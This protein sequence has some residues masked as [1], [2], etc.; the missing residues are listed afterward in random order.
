MKYVIGTRGSK[1]ALAQAQI[2]CDRLRES[3][4]GGENEFEIKIIKTTGDMVQDKPLDKIG[5]KGLFTTQIEEQILSGEV[6]IGVH[7]M[8][9][10]PSY[11]EKGL[12]FT[13]VWSREDPRDALILR[14]AKSLSELPKGAVIATGSKRRQ[15]QLLKMRPDLQVVGIR[16]NVDTRLRKMHEQKLDGIILAVAGLKRL[17]MENVITEYLDFMVPAPAQ[18]A[19]ALEVRADRGDLIA[20]LDSLSDPQ[21][22]FAVRAERGFL[23]NIGADCHVPVGALCVKQGAEYSLKALFGTEDGSVLEEVTVQGTDPEKMA[24][25]AADSIRKKIS[26]KVFLVGGGPGDEGLM[27]LRAMELVKTADCIIYDRLA[28]S[29]PLKKAKPGCELIYVGKADSHHTMTQDEINSLL[30]KKALK[31]R[32]VVRFKGG[33]PFVFGRGGEEALYLLEKNIDFEV[34]PG[35]TSATS[36]LDLAG[37]PITHRG[38]AE[39]FRVVTAHNKDG[40]TSIDFGSMAKGKETCVFLM[41]LSALAYIADGLI[42]A[43][44]DADTPAAVISKASTPEQMVLRGTLGT[45]EELCREKKPRSP[46]IIVVG[47]V[48]ALRDKLA[49]T[50]KGKLLAVKVGDDTGGITRILRDKGFAVEEWTAGRIEYISDDVPPIAD[51]DCIAFTGRNGAEG[52]FRNLKEKKVDIRSLAGVKIAAV[53]KSTAEF[54][55][56]KGICAD[57]IPE[58]FD[59]KHLA[60]AISAELGSEARVLYPCGRITSGSLEKGLDNVTKFICYENIPNDEPIPELEDFDG[61][62]FTCAS[63]AERFLCLVAAEQL[64]CKVFSIGESTTSA[65]KKAGVENIFTVRISDYSGLAETIMTKMCN[66]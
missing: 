49:R 39:G 34:V 19:L 59:G 10:M 52:F 4:P 13:K 63:S 43:G 38:I 32:I 57:I 2:V 42:T 47:E 20:L 6:H 35:V 3:C 45:I 36:A 18:G 8:K 9:D 65:L 30:V 37:I 17:G 1:L 33:D 54:L 51:F 16:G 12:V 56:S 41:G 64:R 60:E 40:K 15:Y 14:E 44:M 48:V 55:M 26:G 28:P 50:P 46:A 29:A 53:G 61:V 7:S 31:H 66:N 62:I 58:K 25:E 11:P 27:T 21:A 5:A 24:A 22:E 23:R